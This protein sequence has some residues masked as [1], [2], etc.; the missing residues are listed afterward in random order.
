MWSL[1]VKIL[2]TVLSG[3]IELTIDPSIE[4]TFWRKKKHE[5]C[6]EKKVIEKKVKGNAKTKRKNEQK[7]DEKKTTNADNRKHLNRGLEEIGKM[8][9]TG[10][11][12]E[13]RVSGCN[14][15]S[16]TKGMK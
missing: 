2:I 12:K 15:K 11:R 6:G 4:K 10:T 1:I 8:A 3:K 16:N 13:K 7:Q 5:G 14:E 9:A